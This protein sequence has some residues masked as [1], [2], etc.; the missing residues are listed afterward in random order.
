MDNPI[1][2]DAETNEETNMPLKGHDTVLSMIVLLLAC[3]VLAA[4]AHIVV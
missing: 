3:L 1:Q 2:N 4:L